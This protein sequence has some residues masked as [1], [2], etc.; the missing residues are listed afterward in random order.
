MIVESTPGVEIPVERVRAFDKPWSAPL[1]NNS[2]MIG[3]YYG[4]PASARQFM[5]NVH[6][7]L[8]VVHVSQPAAGTTR[9]GIAAGQ[10]VNFDATW[11]GMPM[12]DRGI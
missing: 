6:A 9:D 1:G 7:A 10:C 12:I 11:H 3:A 4:D 5:V 2:R 8:R